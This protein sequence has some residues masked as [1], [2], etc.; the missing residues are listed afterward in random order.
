MLGAHCASHAVLAAAGTGAQWWRRGDD[1]TSP[2][3]DPCVPASGLAPGEGGR[4]GGR[5]GGGREG[6]R[7]RGRERGRRKRGREGERE[8]EEREEG[9]KCV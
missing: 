9:K 8:E 3:P 4:E 2:G 7:E 1:A 5:E 6:G